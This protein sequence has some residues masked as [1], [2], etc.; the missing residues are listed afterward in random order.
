MAAWDDEAMADLAEIRVRPP[1][2]LIFVGDPDAEQPDPL[3]GRLVSS[4]RSAI[5]IGTLAEMTARRGSGC[6][7]RLQN[8]RP[9]SRLRSTDRCASQTGAWRSTTR[10]GRRT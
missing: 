8:G 6:R 9:P 3:S 2:S 7:A 4:S 5:A 1:N 10:S